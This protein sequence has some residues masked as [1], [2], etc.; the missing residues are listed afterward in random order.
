MLSI[1]SYV[2]KEDVVINEARRQG[3]KLLFPPMIFSIRQIVR[4]CQFYPGIIQRRADIAKLAV[5]PKSLDDVL[6]LLD[7]TLIQATCLHNSYG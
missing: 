2:P 1:L 3:K 4:Q 5:M 7:V 6:H